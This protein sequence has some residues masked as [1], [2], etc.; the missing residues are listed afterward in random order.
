MTQAEG[1]PRPQVG[2]VLGPVPADLV[3]WLADA[4]AYDAAGVDALWLELSP[5]RR[6]D[7]VVLAAALAVVT[8]RA[9]ILAQLPPGLG[10]DTLAT[11][12]RLGR[13]R[14]RVVTEAERQSWTPAPSPDGRIAWRTTVAD[15]LE[16]GTPGLLVP[17]GGRLLDIL[18]NPDDGDRRDLQLT[19]G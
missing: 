2:V 19:V 5:G 9:Q 1:V 16:R 10:P 3:E 8:F 7:P 17:A 15:A 4:A 6:L 13:G 18:R 12:D 14:V 11:L